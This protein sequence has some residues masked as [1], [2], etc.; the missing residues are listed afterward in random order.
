ML[1]TEA[2]L[3]CDLTDLVILDLNTG[4]SQEEILTLKWSQIDFF[5]KTLQTARN[6]ALKAGTIP[7]N[8]TAL[9]LLKRHPRIAT[10]LCHPFGSKRRRHLHS[11]KTSGSRRCINDSQTLCS[12]LHG[13]LVA[14]GGCFGGVRQFC[15]S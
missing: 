13:K 7:L 14:L 4:L 1:K 2:K 3:H 11:L 8:N 15:Y 9:E 5:R 6:K 10:Y 12:S